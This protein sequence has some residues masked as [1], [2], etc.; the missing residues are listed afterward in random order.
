MNALRV[1]DE[2]SLEYALSCEH[3][4]V[5]EFERVLASLSEY[6]QVLANDQMLVITCRG[7]S[8]AKELGC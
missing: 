5:S 3:V 2:H 1:V 4:L 8:V 7:G 6:L